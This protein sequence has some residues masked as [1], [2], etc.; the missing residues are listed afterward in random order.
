MGGSL[1]LGNSADADMYVLSLPL[2]LDYKMLSVLVYIGGF[3]AATSMIIVETIALS[4]MVSNHLFLPLVFSAKGFTNAEGSLKQKIILSRRIIIAVI[5]LAAYF[6]NGYIAPYFSLVSIGLASMAAVA[7]FSPALFGGLYWRNASRK[8]AITGIIVG[9][10]IWFYT[11]VIPSGIN[12]GFISK[13]VMQNGPWNI[14]WLRPQALFGM[15][16]MDLLSHSLF[17]SMLF[18][19]LCYFGISIYSTLSAQEI[20]QAKIF[21]DI[22]DK[23]ANALAEGRGVW[24]GNTRY[25]DIKALLESFI[26]KERTSFLLNAYA[27]RHHISL[28]TTMADSRIV[29][30]AERVLS[31]IIGSASAKF[32][33]GTVVKEEEEITINEV[34]AIVRESQQAMELNKELKK[35]SIELSRAT[36]M[37]TR[38][39]EQLKQMDAMKDE[40]LYTVTHELRTP[41]TSIRALSEIVY[42]NPEMDEG[43]RQRYLEG[44]VKEIERLSYLITQV[45]NLERYESGRQKLNYSSVHIIS[46]IA[47]VLQSL[48]PLADEKHIQLIQ[49]SPE[50]DI[51]LQL[52]K[53]LIHQA[54]YNLVANA[55]KFSPEVGGKIKI[56]IKESE[57][58]IRLLIEDN[59]PGIP[60]EIR[61]Q[62]FDKFFQAKNQT[63]KKPIG[64]GLGLAICKRI[65]EM[66]HGRI[67]VEEGEGS[68]AR[69]ILLLPLIDPEHSNAPVF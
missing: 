67:W 62:I 28:Q 33:L 65:L 68:G 11:L 64:T 38:A 26:G 37:L 10:A 69:F 20:Y 53:D 29:S 31:G 58:D 6:Y 51:V 66:H 5:L 17:W 44:V 32:V 57:K 21:V 43:Q 56:S 18:N 14:G 8:G 16:G 22:F 35:K 59:G 45:L 39:N 54:L 9:F 60:E 63:L 13:S 19:M 50:R 46:L 24:R 1:I 23:D 52:D 49:V 41:L 47:E 15:E 27:K 40:F 3:S 4:T 36:E 55:L 42:D 25:T 48:K 30:F 61:E 7:Q 12:A 2:H 34:L